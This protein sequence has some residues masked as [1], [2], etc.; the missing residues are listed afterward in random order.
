MPKTLA[1]IFALPVGGNPGMLSVE[2]GFE[3]FRRRHGLDC[4]VH[5]YSFEDDHTPRGASPRRSLER[6]WRDV[7]AADAIVYWGDF[8]QARR[9]HLQDLLARAAKRGP[10]G[11]DL[12]ERILV[13]LMLQGAPD[14][15][16]EKTVLFGGSLLTDDASDACDPTYRAAA[17]RLFS[18]ARGVWMRDA[19]SLSLAAALAGYRRPIQ[20]GVDCAFLLEP[21]RAMKAAAAPRRPLIGW[22]LHR[23]A[24]PR[25][26]RRFIEA[27]GERLG[28]EMRELR[29]FRDPAPLEEKLADIAA[30]DLL[31]TD[32]YHQAVNSWREG[33][34]AVC[35][36]AG[37]ESRTGS[38]TDKKKEAF[39]AGCGARPYY[40]FLEF[41]KG[42]ETFLREVERVAGLLGRP[43]V[44]AAVIERQRAH[45]RAVEAELADTLKTLLAPRLRLAR[46]GWR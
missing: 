19:L 45:L 28:G 14:G 20:L 13:H 1:V 35:I 42:E 7:L 27:L 8:Q 10:A 32:I 44:A 2:A 4:T 34:P 40:V 38:L 31:V 9:F 33:V 17:L 11:A 39:Y 24:A 21:G 36:G 41:L 6:G 18:K 30:C 3:S 12:I 22:S 15:V 16:L 46:L 37:A 26:S 25:R 43:A 29:W 23:S 5:A